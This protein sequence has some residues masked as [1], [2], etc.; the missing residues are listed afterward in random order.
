MPYKKQGIPEEN[1]LVICTVKKILPH[2][3]FVNLDEYDKKEGLVHISEVSPGRIRNLR[4]FVREGKVIV[5]KV[6]SINK[7]RGNIDLSLRRV[8]LSQKKKKEEEYKQELKAEK[9]MEVLA[10]QEKMPIEEFYKRVGKKI[11]EQYGSIS[12]FFNDLIVN[13]KAKVD[14]PEESE[15]VKKLIEIIKEKIRPPEI[16]MESAITLT[17]RESNGIEK[18]RETFKKTKEWAKEKSYKVGVFYISAPKYRIK[19][20]AMNPKEAERIH[21]EVIEHT[22][23]IAKEL[24]VKAEWERKS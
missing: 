14:I 6:L 5:C 4:D 8:S 12:N 19:T 11:I 13:P 24:G 7:E 22:I 21:E 2:S 3:V 20:S 17:N 1:E 18:I 9:L 23:K 15:L 10:K 16:K